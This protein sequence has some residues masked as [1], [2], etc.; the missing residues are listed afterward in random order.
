VVFKREPEGAATALKFHSSPAPCRRERDVYERLK[1]H[2][3]GK[4]P[5]FHVPQRLRSDEF[6]PGI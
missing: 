1:Q 3:A 4:L 6:R 5:G 2:G